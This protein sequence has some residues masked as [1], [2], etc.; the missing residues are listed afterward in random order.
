MEWTKVS[1]TQ[2]MSLY[3]DVY[4]ENG[5]WKGAFHV[6]RPFPKE[7][8]TPEAAMNFCESW[9]RDPWPKMP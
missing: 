1:E 7:F 5:V 4:F 6:Y 2:Y 3:Y 9:S 8:R